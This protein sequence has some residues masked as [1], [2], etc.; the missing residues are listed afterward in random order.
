MIML[1]RFSK[2]SVS[3]KLTL[4]II[5]AALLAVTLS[6]VMNII[7]QALTV[8]NALQHEIETTTEILASNVA[9]SLYFV[10]KS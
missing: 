7:S 6:G 2:L 3:N 10:S 8:N 9:A 5:C 4:I 1:T